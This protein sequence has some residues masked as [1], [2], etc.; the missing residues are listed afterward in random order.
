LN[1]VN[2]TTTGSTQITSDG[3]RCY[4]M[5]VPFVFGNRADFAQLIKTYRSSQ[6]ETRY[7][8]ATIESIEAKPQFGNPDPAHISTSYSERY[9]LSVR[10]HNRRFTRL[11]NAHSKSGEH[12]AAMIAIFIAYYNFGRTHL[13]HKE[14]GKRG[15]TP[16]MAAGLT[17]HVWSLEELLSAVAQ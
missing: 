16:A 14:K 8:P 6:S 9:N 4:T 11:T 12:H 17:D 3:Y 10:M 13:A 7:S 5:N 2:C 1:R 15:R